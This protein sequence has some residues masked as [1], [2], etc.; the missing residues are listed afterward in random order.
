MRKAREGGKMPGVEISFFFA[1]HQALSATI[2]LAMARE[3]PIQRPSEP[4]TSAIDWPAVLAE[5]GRWLRTVV[6]ARVADRAAAADVMQDI[7][8]AAIGKG[9]QLRD[10]SKVAPWLYR[11]AVMAALQYRRRQGRRRKQLERYVEHVPP[12]E[13]DA[14][15][16]DPLDWLLAGERAALV[17]QALEHLPRRDVEILLLKYSEDW[18][19][20]QLAEHLGLST[21]AVEAR[22]HRA[23]RK[24]R[25]ALVRLDPDVVEM[26]GNA[27]RIS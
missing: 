20:R 26:A 12:A 7:A 22:L 11:L 5:H 23:R 4:A 27:R 17:R 25:R 10:S 9:H 2:C 21:S 15:E 1:R 6:L 24:L 14:R 13:H 19:Y 18:S 16:P 3:N 8:A